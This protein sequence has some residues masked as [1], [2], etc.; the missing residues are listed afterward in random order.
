MRQIREMVSQALWL[1]VFVGAF[2]GAALLVPT[3]LGGDDVSAP[4]QGAGA[5][6]AAA[7]VVLPY[8]AARAFDQVT[9]PAPRTSAE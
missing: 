3:I 1:A 8:C 7:C 2:V 4:Q 9:R 5:A 6:M